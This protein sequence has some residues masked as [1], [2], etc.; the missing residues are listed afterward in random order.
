VA[1]IAEVEVNRQTGH[2]WAKPLACA[3]DCGLVILPPYGAGEAA[4]K[5]MLAAIVNAIY[6]ATACASG[7]SR[8]AMIASSVH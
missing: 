8:F 1:Q 5:P 2:V 7:G 6:D 3:H 4:L